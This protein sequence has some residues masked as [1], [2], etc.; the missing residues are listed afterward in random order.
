MTPKEFITKIKPVDKQWELEPL[1]TGSWVYGDLST[2]IGEESENKA[3]N[4]LNKLRQEFIKIPLIDEVIQLKEPQKTDRT[5]YYLY[6]AW[7]TLFA[8]EGSDWFWWYGNDWD[9]GNDQYFSRLHRE[10]MVN[11]LKYLLKAGYQIEFPSLVLEPLDQDESY[12][13]PSMCIY[14]IQDT[15]LNIKIINPLNQKIDL[16]NFIINITD[17]NGKIIFSEKLSNLKQIENGDIVFDFS[18]LGLKDSELNIN[19]INSQTQEI[20]DKDYII[21]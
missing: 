14:N 1:A 18:N 20:V 9:S 21:K 2:W 19:I 17:L 11:A 12:L 15:K 8:T 10:L 13:P 3:W 5:K 6:K 7:H 4:M 16:N